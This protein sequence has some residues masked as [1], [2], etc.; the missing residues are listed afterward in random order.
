MDPDA[1]TADNNTPSPLSTSSSEAPSLS[2]PPSFVAPVSSSNP[3]AQQS[4]GTQA[5]PET[6]NKASALVQA[7]HR[8]M[9]LATEP[10][11]SYSSGSLESKIHNFLHGNPAFSSLDLNLSAKPAPERNNFSPAAGTDNQ[12]GTPVRDEGGGTPTQDEIMDKP[13]VRTN[14]LTVGELVKA[15]SGL[16]EN[17]AQPLPNSPLLQARSLPSASQNGQVFHSFPYG[18]RDLSEGG[19]TAPVAHYPVQTG[20]PVSGDGAAGGASGAQTI[21]SFKEGNEQSWFGDHYP[22]GSSQQPGGYNVSAPGGAGENNTPGLYP[23]QTEQTQEPQ[24]VSQQGTTAA[25]SFFKNALPPVPKLPPP[26]SAFDFSLP[27]TGGMMNPPE[28]E[29]MPSTNVEGVFG[30]TNVEGVFGNTGDSIIS[31]MVVYD[32]QHTLHPDNSFHDPPRPH[33]NELRYQEEMGHYRDEP[34]QR[35]AQFPYDDPHY[36][37]DDPYF[38][39]GSPPQPYPRVRVRLSPPPSGDQ[40]FA[41]DYQRHSLPPPRPNYAPRRPPPPREIRHPG[42]RP[43]HR[44]PHP[45][46]L[47]HPRGPPRAPFSHSHGPELR[48][49]GKRPGPRIRGPMFPPKRPFLPPRY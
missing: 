23:Y 6:S 34:R 27:S 2:M 30:S 33:P 42:P 26:P 18:K 9:D 28:Q 21:E 32:H 31:G 1:P 17:S 3:A 41:R 38:R 43:P 15:A 11:P 13:V 46:L 25:S 44:P 47:P 36:P 7:L 48:F 10:E 40:R 45:A 8:D 4:S 49:R 14:Q 24:E 39:P 35:D 37:P 29:P 5:T 20:G 22:G 16:F 12:D 19:V